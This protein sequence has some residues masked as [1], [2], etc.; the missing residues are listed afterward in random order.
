MVAVASTGTYKAIVSITKVGVC[1][2]SSA[3]AAALL[4][5]VQ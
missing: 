4:L 3:A 5:N 2:C 1:F